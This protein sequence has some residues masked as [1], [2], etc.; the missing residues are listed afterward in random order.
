MILFGSIIKNSEK[1]ICLTSQF[2]S[3]CQNKQIKITDESFTCKWIST[4]LK[5]YS[6]D[7]QINPL[8]R[9]WL[10]IHKSCSAIKRNLLLIMKNRFV[11]NWI[12]CSWCYKK[13]Y[14]QHTSTRLSI[15]QSMNE[16]KR[17][18]DFIALTGNNQT[19]FFVGKANNIR[20]SDIFQ[21]LWYGNDNSTLHFFIYFN[22]KLLYFIFNCLTHHDTFLS[23]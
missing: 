21:L 5:P 10:H 7:L 13:V 4:S 23:L 3:I 14:E 2:S 15:N 8:A 11:I 9:D 20:C 22:L 12:I 6:C 19:Y 1:I 18:Y 16:L 17:I